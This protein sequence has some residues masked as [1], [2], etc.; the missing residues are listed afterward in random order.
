MKPEGQVKHRLNQAL[1]RH[2]KREIRTSLSKRPE[3][4]VHNAEVSNQSVKVRLCV[5]PTTPGKHDVCDV[6][7]GGLD[8][9]QGC[10]YF[11]CK[12]T[13]D[14]VKADFVSLLSKPDRSEVAIKYPD[15]AAYFWTLGMDSGLPEGWLDEEPKEPA[16]HSWRI[17]MPGDPMY[18]VTIFWAT[19]STPQPWHQEG[20]RIFW[21][22][23]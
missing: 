21:R 6:S 16:P 22:V 2:L 13:K 8:K 10:P 5:L 9:A 4:C 17:N 19:P 3:N 1:F 7:Y 11:E 14:S 12:H 23:M 18:W 20:S 15:V